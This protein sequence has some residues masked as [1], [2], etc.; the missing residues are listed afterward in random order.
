MVR[1]QKGD[2]HLGHD[3]EETLVNCLTEVEHRFVYTNFRLITSLHTVLDTFLTVPVDDSVEG[4]IR[5]HRGGP[6]A[7]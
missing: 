2:T 4:T 3:L 7:N 6:V 1:G 5:D